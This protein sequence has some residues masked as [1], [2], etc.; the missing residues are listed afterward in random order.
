MMSKIISKVNV[1]DAVEQERKFLTKEDLR[2][3]NFFKKKSNTKRIL[4][5][6]YCGV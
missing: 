3:I 6:K 5:N 1:R 2:L 4:G